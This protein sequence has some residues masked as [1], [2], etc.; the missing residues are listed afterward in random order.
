MTA[1]IKAL[2]AD[3]G[4][5]LATFQASLTEFS[6]GVAADIKS[7]FVCD[8]FLGELTELDSKAHKSGERERQ[9]RKARLNHDP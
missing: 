5:T 8:I 6:T 4:K 7:R 2:V 9:K 3:P 1:A